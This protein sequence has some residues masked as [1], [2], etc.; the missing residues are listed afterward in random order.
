M[1]NAAAISIAATPSPVVSIAAHR[2]RSTTSDAVDNQRASQR[3]ADALKLVGDTLAPLRRVVRAGDV[4][5][6][7]GDAFGNLYVM[8]SGF[9]KLTRKPRPAS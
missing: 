5:Y 9:F 3:I 1:L 6:H 2:M 7:A 4:I 8:N